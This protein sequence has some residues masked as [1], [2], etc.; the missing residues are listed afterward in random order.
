[1]HSAGLILTLRCE[2]FSFSGNSTQWE[3]FHLQPG[4]NSKVHND[5]L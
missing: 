5:H 2:K 4:S 3:G 1:M